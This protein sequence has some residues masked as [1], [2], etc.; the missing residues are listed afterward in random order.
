[1]VDRVMF[2]SEK[3]DWETPRKL[4]EEL[5]KEFN[6]E[7]DIA[8]SKENSKCLNYIDEEQDALSISWKGL[9]NIFCNPPYK[10]DVQTAFVKKAYEESLKTGQRIVLLIPVRTDTK[11]W[12]DYIIGKAEVRFI[13]G[14]LKFENAG[15]PHKDG[16][17]FPSAIVI[18]N[19]WRGDNGS[20]RG[21]INE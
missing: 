13:R 21:A 10:S 2:S 9:G 18:Y 1:M 14:R 7:T 16:A 19:Y 6:F 17:T 12:Q 5:N 20:K 4:F 15:V 8:A 11:R 3:Q